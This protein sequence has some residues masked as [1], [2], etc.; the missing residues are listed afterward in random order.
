MDIRSVGD[1]LK[2]QN[3]FLRNADGLSQKGFTQIPNAILENPAI[4]AGAK[5]TYVMLLR[6]AFNKGSCFPGQ[7]TLAGDMAVSRQSASKYIQ[8]LER[9]GFIKV[10]RQGQGRPNLYEVDL[11]A[12]VLFARRD[13]RPAPRRPRPDVKNPDIRM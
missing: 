2:E 11:M 9:R 3:I 8:E 10:K 4:S 5:L 6:Y 1:I 7:D 12:K 13:P